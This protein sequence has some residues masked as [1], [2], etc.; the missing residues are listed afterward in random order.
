MPK[1]VHIMLNISYKG[2]YLRTKHTINQ[3]IVK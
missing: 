2:K 1:V 3:V